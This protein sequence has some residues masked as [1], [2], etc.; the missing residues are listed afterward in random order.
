MPG[1]IFYIGKDDDYTERLYESLGG[2]HYFLGVYASGEAALAKLKD[3][4]VAA[5]IGP[6]I[7]QAEAEKAIAGFRQAN[8]AVITVSSDYTPNGVDMHLDELPAD[9]SKLAIIIDKCISE[10]LAAVAAAEE[11]KRKLRKK[12][13]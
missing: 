6:S 5:V 8:L 2:R 3:K 11:E 12:V 13:E 4:H 1:F 7:P 10:K 9:V